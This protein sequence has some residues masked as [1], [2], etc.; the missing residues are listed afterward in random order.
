MRCVVEA[1]VVL[2]RQT[3]KNLKRTRPGPDGQDASRWYGR[4]RVQ[5]LTLWVLNCAHAPRQ[6]EAFHDLHFLDQIALPP[7]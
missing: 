2:L 4:L 3:K 6:S 1:D 5:K 7:C